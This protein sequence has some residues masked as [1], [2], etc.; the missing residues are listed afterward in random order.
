MSQI[1]TN[2]EGI[3]KDKYQPALAN[4]IN[5]EPSPFLEMIRKEPLTNNKVRV[6]API[7]IN[8]GFGFGE[9]GISTP[10]SAA[11]RY[12]SFE[13]KAVDMYVDIS[14][15]NK[16]MVL[17]SS[18]Q[19][20]MINA[21]DAEVKGSYA[22]A[23]WNLSR[24]LFGDGSGLLAMM[25]PAEAT[26]TFTV[27]N[28]ENLI[29]G[30][31]VD[32]YLLDE[33]MNNFDLYEEKVRIKGV[34]HLKKTVTLERSYS[35]ERPVNLYVQGSRDR[36][37]CGLGAIFKT[38]NQ[39]PT[40]YGLDRTENSWLVPEEIAMNGKK[41]SDMELYRGIRRA[42]KTHGSKIDLLMMSDKAFDLYQEYMDGRSTHVVNH[43]KFQGGAVGYSILVGDQEVVI[44]NESRVPDGE[45]WGVDT[46]SFILQQTPWEFVTDGGGIFTLQANSSIF[47]ALL[48]SYGNLICTN[49]GGCVRFF[50]CGVG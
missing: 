12:A 29:E 38:V 15:S 37:L 27:D 32:L 34:D 9:E 42:R 31:V 35:F 1:L 23:K 36:E 14:V 6:A 24:A 47:R 21:L 10:S 13:V 5:T 49:P 40:L 19:G 30:L 22:A 39:S 17:G 45:I 46:Q 26:D 43:R 20:A 50:A 3:L 8:G 2:I 44:I 18:D 25:Q 11:Q 4:L 33:E 7:G 28:A 41:V 48:A 16:T